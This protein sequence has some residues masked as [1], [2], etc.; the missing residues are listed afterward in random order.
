[1]TTQA[2]PRKRAPRRKK[3]TPADLR[4]ALRDQPLV[5]LVAAAKILQV[6]PP[7]VS[8]LRKQGRMP[9][10]VEVKGSALVYMESEVLAL[11]R[12]LDAERDDRANGEEG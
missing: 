1:M 8:R 11:A 9:A 6:A 5:G 3:A 12:E 2:K 4:L 10:G 7:N